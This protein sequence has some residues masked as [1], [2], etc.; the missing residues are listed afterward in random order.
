[1]RRLPLIPTL[2]VGLAVAV[3]IALG[4]WQL[5]RGEEKAAALQ[6]YRANLVLPATAYPG[7]N[8]TD[9]AYLFR[10]VSAHCLTVTG[11]RTMGGRLPGGSPGWRHIA[12]CATGAEGPGFQVDAG[13]SADPNLKPRWTGGTVRGTAIWEPESSSALMRW[14]GKAPPPRLMIV[15]AEPIPGL[16][17]SPRPD[18]AGVPNNHLAYAVQWFLFAGVALVIYGLAARWRGAPRRMDRME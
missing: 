6:Q 9:A 12:S 1:M 3:M 4:F 7:S 14:L 11:W 18:P 16:K 2:V 10:T 5:R 17:P 13:M 15:A 8:P